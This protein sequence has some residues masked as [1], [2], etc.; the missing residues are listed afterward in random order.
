MKKRIV[1]IAGILI[2]V[3]LAVS[4][5]FQFGWSKSGGGL[6]ES[7]L[8]QESLSGGAAET[9]KAI[10][11][12]GDGE[13][14]IFVQ[15]PS[16]TAVFTQAGEQLFRQPSPLAKTTM[17]DLNGD[18]VDEFVIATPASGGIQ[19][20]AY[21]LSGG[22]LWN[23]QTQ[24]NGV[25][26]RAATIDFQGDGMREIIVA[27]TLGEIIALDG[28]NGQE[29]WRYTFPSDTPEN[30]EVRGSDD[31]LVNGKLFLVAG[32]YGGNMALLD[33]SGKEVWQAKFPE[34]IRR[35]RA[36]DMNGD[37][38]SELILG[39]LN[40]TVVLASAA[41]GKFIWQNFLG[42]RV[43]EARFIELDG[44]PTTIEVVIGTKEKGLAVFS[45]DGKKLWSKGV[46]GKVVELAGL[47]AD[48]DGT[49][50]LLAAADKVTLLD[51]KNGD[52]RASFNLGTVS[53]MDVGDLGKEQSFVAGTTE[54]LTTTQV[55]AQPP[56]WYASPLLIGIVL[57]LVIAVAALLLS[58]AQLTEK[59]LIYSVVDDSPE[60]L[61]A[62][63]RM[64]R[65]EI[66]DLEKMK[67]A[68]ELAP[69][70]YAESKRFARE[71]L[72][73][74]EARLQKVQPDYKPQ[75]VSCPSCGGPVEISMDRCEYCG[76]V[77]M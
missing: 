20:T 19:L 8:W 13:D 65:E 34:Q 77:L 23:S 44:D 17:G 5:F 60:T 46:S 75:V 61:Q 50:E 21:S 36:Y 72:A 6:K 2:V 35:L 3:V 11:L 62:Q 28:A 42:S 7:T 48:G 74:V 51:G 40:G 41:D 24:A 32:D 18:K 39:G 70:N 33:G 29:L 56:K 15:T 49:Q 47:D 68:G 63:K 38:T 31:A 69:E 66:D 71:R 14:E 55:S 64:L 57:A 58:R 25:P 1:I 4:A 76:H 37:G 9:L 67:T 53:T 22:E 73:D 52:Q 10:D 27:T 59:P 30:L 45:F 43:Q 16:E 26:A 54:G 12:T